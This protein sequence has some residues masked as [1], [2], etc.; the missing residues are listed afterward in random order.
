MS[1]HEPRYEYKRMSSLYRNHADLPALSE[2]ER[3]VALN[4]AAS[5][6]MGDPAGAAIQMLVAVAILNGEKGPVLAWPAG[7]SREE[8]AAWHEAEAAWYRD[9]MTSGS[10]SAHSRSA[11][12]SP[13][14]HHEKIESLPLAETPLP[15]ASVPQVLREEQ[16]ENLPHAGSDEPEQE[17]SDAC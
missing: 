4:A 14:S 10:M 16:K 15:S 13:Q 9:L 17:S 11:E 6:V 8:K 5:R 7:T 12:K 1:E 2:R 3:E